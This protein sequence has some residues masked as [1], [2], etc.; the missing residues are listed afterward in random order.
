MNCDKYW[1]RDKQRDYFAAR[2]TFTDTNNVEAMR[3]KIRGIKKL[4]QKGGGSNKYDVDKL[5]SSLAYWAG[6]LEKKQH[7]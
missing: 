6:R 3:E 5:K 1:S 2:R 4:V 7:K